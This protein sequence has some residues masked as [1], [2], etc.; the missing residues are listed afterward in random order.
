MTGEVMRTTYERAP[1]AVLIGVLALAGCTAEDSSLK[2]DTPDL[3]RA[4]DC[5][6]GDYYQRS[7][8]ESGT[9]VVRAKQDGKLIRLDS[10]GISIPNAKYY[11]T[12]PAT[13]KKRIEL[14]ADVDFPD[15]AGEMV[16]WGI[17]DGEKKDWCDTE[18]YPFDTF[19][20]PPLEDE[21]A[22]E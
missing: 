2:P 8:T 15:M 7:G 14:P 20:P 10:V 5:L 4:F 13:G 22:T 16:I 21:R 17:V 3:P 19:T 1:A 12:F 9:I 18:T 11:E 6:R